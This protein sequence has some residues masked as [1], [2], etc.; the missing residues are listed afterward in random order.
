[1]YLVSIKG[2]LRLFCTAT[3]QVAQLRDKKILNRQPSVTR[4]V[5]VF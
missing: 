5:A 2:N 3:K 4:D 1:M